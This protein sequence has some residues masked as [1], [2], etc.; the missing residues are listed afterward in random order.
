MSLEDL[1]MAGLILPEEEWGKHSLKT[2]VNRLELIIVGVCAFASGL[3]M[4]FGNGHLLTWIGLTLFLIC[5][6]AFTALSI[7]AVEKQAL[8]EEMESKD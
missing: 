4:Y 3:M 6:G 2:T 5:L 8:R 7:V 1:K